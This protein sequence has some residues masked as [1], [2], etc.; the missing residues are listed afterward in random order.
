MCPVCGCE[1]TG[2]LMFGEYTCHCGWVT[3][4]KMETEETKGES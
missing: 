2:P 3:W 1:L 4:P